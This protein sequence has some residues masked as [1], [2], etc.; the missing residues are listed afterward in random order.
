MLALQSRSENQKSGQ[1]GPAQSRRRAEAKA[2]PKHNP[3][4]Q[5][6]SLG[7]AGI[8]RKLAI[9]KSGD[10][11]EQEADRMADLVLSGSASESSRRSLPITPFTTASAQRKCAQCEDEEEDK[12]QRKEAGGGAASPDAAPPEVHDTLGSSGQPLEPETRSFFEQRFGHDFDQVRVHTDA[13]AAESARSVSA[14]AYTVGHHIVFGAGQYVPHAAGGRRLI[15]HELTHV[16]QQSDGMLMRAP[17]P[18]A[19]DEFNQR[20]QKIKTLKPYADLPKDSKKQV[21]EILDETRKRDNPLYYIGK[22]EQVFNTPVDDPAKTA[23]HFSDETKKAAE[24]E[25]DRLWSVRGI[26]GY[27]KEEIISDQRASAAGFKKVKGGDGKTTFEI[28]AR[29]PTNIAVRVKVRL[30]K[31]GPVTTDKDIINI[32]LQEDAIEKRSSTRGY[33]VDLEFVDKAGPDVFTVEVDTRSWTTSGNWVGNDAGL[34]HELH[35]LLGLDD[36]Y[37]YIAAHSTNPKMI[38]SDRVFWF[39]QELR[40]QIDNKEDSIMNSGMYVPLDDDICMVAG[41]RNKNDIDACVKKRVEDRN[42]VLDPAVAMARAPMF[43]ALQILEGTLAPSPHDRKSD[44]AKGE[45]TVGESKQQRALSMAQSIFGMP[46]P[47]QAAAA[48]IRFMHFEMMTRNLLMVSELSK[49]CGDGP[50]SWRGKAPGILLCPDFFSLTLAAQADALQIEA[51]HRA[52]IG[53]ADTDT[54]CAKPGCDDVCGG[55]TNAR[56]WVRLINCVAD[57]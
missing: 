53:G 56:A 41:N 31:A 35:H 33:S 21:E 50:T 23:K 6:L 25:L 26:L 34:A 38:V 28:D 27:G 4:W 57:L 18:A 49:G 10:L 45:S 32:K 46:Y 40:K 48:N 44:P 13:S 30:I 37:D 12:L 36:R 52:G 55:S 7:H 11:H 1:D 9:G 20:A 42:K 22:L 8:Q 3:L 54:R 24:D 16:L 29:D 39:L 2:P 47:A 51:A 5:S 17:D 14:L 15:A 43:N 19:V